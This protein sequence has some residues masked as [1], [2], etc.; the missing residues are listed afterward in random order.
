MFLTLHL[1]ITATLSFKFTELCRLL[2]N[3]ENHVCFFLSRRPK[4]SSLK[5]K[6]SR[7]RFNSFV[8]TL[9]NPETL[10]EISLQ[11]NT[12][13]DHWF[14]TESLKIIAGFI[15]NHP[16]LKGLNQHVFEVFQV[17]ILPNT[18]KML[19]ARRWLLKPINQRR[20]YGITSTSTCLTLKVWG[21]KKTLPLSN[22]RTSAELSRCCQ[23]KLAA[24]SGRGGWEQNGRT[25]FFAVSEQG[26]S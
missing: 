21:A 20:V 22:C 15:K 9:I 18:Q 6:K 26:R 25:R 12:Q 7:F 17:S 14:S 19:Q 8:W 5:Q 13:D 11:L 23:L 1:L 10:K 2:A 4:F 3:E 16:E 24:L